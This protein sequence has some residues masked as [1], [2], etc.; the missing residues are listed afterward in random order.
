[1]Y[2]YFNAC[3]SDHL[4]GISDGDEQALTH[5]F[6]EYGCVLYGV[7]LEMVTS[8]E[9][10]QDVMVRTYQRIWCE[11]CAYDPEQCRPLSWMLKIVRQEGVLIVS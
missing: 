2:A 10:A 5:L 11:A 9:E 4:T 6:D 3:V 1:M 8:E 7:A